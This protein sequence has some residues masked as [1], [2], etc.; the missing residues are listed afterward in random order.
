MK[1]EVDVSE[2]G[3]V[4]TTSKYLQVILGTFTRSTAVHHNHRVSG[5]SCAVFR[6]HYIML[7]YP[8]EGRC[9]STFMYS[10]TNLVLQ[11]NHDR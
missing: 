1:V 6:V 8:P 3:R 2:G 11:L 10:C 4:S 9:R 5:Q 7:K